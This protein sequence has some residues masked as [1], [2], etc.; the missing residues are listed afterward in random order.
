M[1]STGISH[2][3]E[4]TTLCG[5]VHYPV[6][7]PF[8]KMLTRSLATFMNAFTGEVLF[9]VHV[10]ITYVTLSPSPSLSLSLS[11]LLAN[12]W[13]FY[14]FSTQN[15]NDYRNLL[16][17][18]CDCVFYPNLKKMDFHQEGWRLEHEDPNDRNTPLVFKGVVFNEMKG[19]FVSQQKFK[20]I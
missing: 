11:L 5:S 13:T 12:D 9:K 17:I 16:S 3:L 15:Y 20:S 18:Y 1:D 8:F 14:P 10:C 4:H 6:R 2:I 19:M 7:D